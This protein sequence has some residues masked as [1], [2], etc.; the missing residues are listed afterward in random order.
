MNVASPLEG[1]R[2]VDRIKY[3]EFKLWNRTL[4]A[5][6]ARVTAFDGQ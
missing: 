3:D 6:R 2:E 1:F 5:W 4:R